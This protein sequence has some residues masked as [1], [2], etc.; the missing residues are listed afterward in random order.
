MGVRIEIVGP[1]G[2]EPYHAQL[3][4]LEAAIEYPIAEGG[5]SFTIDH[6]EAYGAFFSALGEALFMIAV[7]GDEL[8]GVCAG[9]MRSGRAGGRTVKTVYGADFKLAPRV[10]GTGLS[11]RMIWSGFLQGVRPSYLRRWRLAYVAA[12]RGARGDVMRTVR[13]FNVGKLAQAG[14]RLAVYFVEPA[15]LAALRVGEAPP[16]PPPTGLD[17][18]PDPA[19]RAP[20]IVSTAGRK[21]LRL[22]STGAPWPLVHL[23][24]GPAA[25]RPSLGAYLRGAGEAIVAEGLTGP[26]CFAVDERLGE[27]IAWL[28]AQ[29]LTAGATCTVYTFGFPGAP[30]PQPWVH[31]ATSEI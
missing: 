22:R 6:G 8:V 9:V 23:P 11:R 21:D 10:R 15:R 17:L 29:G 2:L 14:A 28:A 20:G 5:D 3:R 13:G 1:D 12:M 25:W 27:Q 7:D 16:P 30:R 18:S 19:C 31:L 26:A 24:L 4:R